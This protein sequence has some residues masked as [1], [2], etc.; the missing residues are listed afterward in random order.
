M[1]AVATITAAARYYYKYYS[2]FTLSDVRVK[3]YKNTIAKTSDNAYNISLYGSSLSWHIRWKKITGRE[4]WP[5]TNHA[6][7]QSYSVR[8]LTNMQ[9]VLNRVSDRSSHL[10][11]KRREKK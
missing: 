1:R 5:T 8:D 7:A 6:Q 3:G 2:F 10:T 9:N 11:G 4:C